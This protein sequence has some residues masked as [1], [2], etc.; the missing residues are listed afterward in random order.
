[1]QSRARAHACFHIWGC[2]WCFRSDLSFLSMT[3]CGTSGNARALISMCRL[4]PLLSAALGQTSVLWPCATK[5]KSC[6][7]LG[8]VPIDATAAAARGPPREQKC[9]CKQED[10]APAEL[11]ERRGRFRTTR[12][13]SGAQA[14]TFAGKGFQEKNSVVVGLAHLLSVHGTSSTKVESIGGLPT[15]GSVAQKTFPLGGHDSRT[16]TRIP[17]LMDLPKFSKAKSPFCCLMVLNLWVLT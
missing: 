14:E 17:C 16:H 10:E 4:K 13:Q 8:A 6:K 11:P 3:C 15:L 9:P 2:G 7:L 1:M 5:A 12:R